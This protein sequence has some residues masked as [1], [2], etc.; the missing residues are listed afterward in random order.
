MKNSIKVL[1]G[2]F[3][4][5]FV[6]LIVVGII[7]DNDSV[8]RSAADLPRILYHESFN[9]TEDEYFVYFWNEFCG[10]CVQFDPD[11]V[12]AHNDGLPI[13][14]VDMVS[15]E[16]AGA[17]FQGEP[18]FNNQFPQ[19]GNEIEISWTPTILH[20]RNGVVV[21]YGAGISEG[22]ALFAAFGE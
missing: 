7:R 18:G 21:G 19:N 10:A 14:V 3:G 8:V 6:G 11:V 20:F 13:Y 1:L 12:S 9:Q 5:L 2:A 16:N 15:D 17:W 22:N 4:A